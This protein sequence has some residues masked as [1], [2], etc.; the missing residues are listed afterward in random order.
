MSKIIFAFALMGLMA[1]AF[2]GDAPDMSRGTKRECK[3]AYDSYIDSDG[4]LERFFK[5]LTRR[6]E[7]KSEKFDKLKDGDFLEEIDEVR[8]FCK[9]DRG[10]KRDADKCTFRSIKKDACRWYWRQQNDNIDR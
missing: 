3:T 1:V 8:E 7:R 4:D 6:I 9:V 5:V 2:A 10:G